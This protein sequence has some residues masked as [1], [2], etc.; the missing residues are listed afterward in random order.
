[1][2]RKVI[3]LHRVDTG[4]EAVVVATV[5]KDSVEYNVLSEN[6]NVRQDLRSLLKSFI[7]NLSPAN[8]NKKLIYKAKISIPDTK[9]HLIN[10]IDLLSWNGYVVKQISDKTVEKSA[11]GLDGDQDEHT[12]LVERTYPVLPILSHYL[13]IQKNQ[14]SNGEL[15]KSFSFSSGEKDYMKTIGGKQYLI[16]VPPGFMLENVE[17]GKI[18]LPGQFVGQIPIESLGQKYLVIPIQQEGSINFR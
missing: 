8:V 10:L 5:D 16:R 15:L 13:K 14:E 12:S 3:Q 17:T 11:L 1:M 18:Y 7:F 9:E 4:A 6:E 2:I